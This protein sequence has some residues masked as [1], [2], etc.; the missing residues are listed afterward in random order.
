MRVWGFRALQGFWVFGAPEGL[1]FYKDLG[2][3][4][5]VSEP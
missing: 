4:V 1:G 5:R 3:F 2:F